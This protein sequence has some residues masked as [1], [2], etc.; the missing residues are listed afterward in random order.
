ML[1]SAAVGILTAHSSWPWA[2]WSKCPGRVLGGK[3]MLA[4]VWG[5]RCAGGDPMTEKG[6]PASVNFGLGTCPIFSHCLHCHAQVHQCQSSLFTHACSQQLMVKQASLFQ[7][8]GFS[9]LGKIFGGDCKRQKNEKQFLTCASMQFFLA[10]ALA[11]VW[12]HESEPNRQHHTA[13]HEVWC[14]K[15]PLSAR[16]VL[17]GVQK[18]ISRI[19]FLGT[20]RRGNGVL[21]HLFSWF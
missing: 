12:R 8:F 6:S 1:F 2:L 10:L 15:R 13:P 7:G 21:R 20:G 17:P 18:W 9:Q 3:A 19:T 14:P 5:T 11:T 16:F 4:V